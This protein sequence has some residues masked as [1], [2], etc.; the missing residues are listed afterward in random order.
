MRHERPPA[1][2]AKYPINAI[3]KTLGNAATTAEKSRPTMKTFKSLLEKGS[4]II[5]GIT[6]PRNN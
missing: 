6:Q 3:R 1:N 5:F 2:I 4:M